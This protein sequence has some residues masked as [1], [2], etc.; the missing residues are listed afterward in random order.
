MAPSNHHR[1]YEEA[2]LDYDQT[3]SPKGWSEEHLYANAITPMRTSYPL[4]TD[5]I[6]AIHN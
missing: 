3:L 6:K 1:R 2:T 4:R 5:F